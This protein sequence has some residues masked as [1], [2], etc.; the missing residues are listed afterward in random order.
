MARVLF[1]IQ[2]CAGLMR[3]IVSPAQ[4][5][6]LHARLSREAWSPV[7]EGWPAVGLSWERLVGLLSESRS[8]R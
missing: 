3:E 5:A 8:G 2:G 4:D 6:P 1:L 7:R